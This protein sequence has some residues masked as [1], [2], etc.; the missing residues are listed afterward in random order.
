MDRVRGVLLLL[1]RVQDLVRDAGHLRAL[2]GV[3]VADG[4]LHRIGAGADVHASRQARRPS[5]CVA[6]AVVH[7]AEGA[8][9][10]PAS[11][12]QYC[13]KTGTFDRPTISSTIHRY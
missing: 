4:G 9:A 10:V 5:P 11:E 6:R 13:I 7:Q 12:L 1:L 3:E 2:A 8:A